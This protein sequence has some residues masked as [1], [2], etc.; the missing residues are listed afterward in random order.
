MR[1]KF[2]KIVSEY[3]AADREFLDAEIEASKNRFLDP[4]WPWNGLVMSFSTLGGSKNWTRVLQNYLNRLSWEAI[5]SLSD[6]E[7]KGLFEALPNPRWR[8][9]TAVNLEAAFQ[10]ISKSGGP[11]IVKEAYQKLETAK[12]RIRFFLNFDGIGSK[13][14]RNIPMDAYDAVVSRHYAIDHRINKILKILIPEGYTYD[15]GEEFLRAC[16][17]EAGCDDWSFDR[18]VYKNHEGIIRRLGV[19]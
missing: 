15:Q 1:D 9:K 13:Y 4:D 12:E 10:K 5:C 16:A 14:S 3:L 8:K 18:V 7:R 6:L 19:K 2:I 11:I 17:L